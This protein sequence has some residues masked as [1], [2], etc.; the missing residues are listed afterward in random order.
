MRVKILKTGE[1]HAF[2]DSYA[3]RLIEQ[4]RAIPAPATEKAAAAS[5]EAEAEPAPAEKKTAK[6]RKEKAS[7]KE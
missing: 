5:D 6:V 2:N 1:G 3:A 7:G 4:G